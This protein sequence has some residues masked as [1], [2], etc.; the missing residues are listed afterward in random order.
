MPDKHCLDIKKKTP[1]LIEENKIF[2]KIRKDNRGILWI[3]P[4][5]KILVKSSAKQM[6]SVQMLALSELHEKYGHIFFTTLKNLPE[7]PKFNIKNKP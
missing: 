2:Y 4:E 1:K 6:V 7:C 5:N 3:R